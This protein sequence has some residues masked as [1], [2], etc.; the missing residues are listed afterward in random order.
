MAECLRIRTVHRTKRKAI[1]IIMACW[2][3]GECTKKGV[4]PVS[5]TARKIET[6]SKDWAILKFPVRKIKHFATKI[7]IA[8]V[9]LWIL[10]HFIGSSFLLF[11]F[12]AIFN[13]RLVG[14]FIETVGLECRQNVASH[15]NIESSLHDRYLTY[16]YFIIKQWP[17][18]PDGWYLLSLKKPAQSPHES[19]ICRK[20]FH[21]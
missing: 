10:Q 18:K 12:F 11:K 15:C 5:G 16:L 9:F 20:R 14:F 21:T 6:M 8:N 7:V 4:F 13:F 3:R 2:C 1:L 19:S 17:T